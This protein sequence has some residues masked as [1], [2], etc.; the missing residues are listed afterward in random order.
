MD[1]A[2]DFAAAEKRRTLQWVGSIGAGIAGVGVGGGSDVAGGGDVLAPWSLAAATVAGME[3]LPLLSRHSGGAIED[4]ATKTAP[5]MPRVVSVPGSRPGV[6]FSGAQRVE[7]AGSDNAAADAWADETPAPFQPASAPPNSA[8]INDDRVTSPPPFYNGERRRERAMTASRRKKGFSNPASPPPRGATIA[9]MPTPSPRSYPGGAGHDD[10]PLGMK[11][12]TS[13]QMPAPSTPPVGATTPA[14]PTVGV[15][16]PHT[17]RLR[18]LSES[19]ADNFAGVRRR[20]E[21]SIMHG[22]PFVSW[23]NLVSAF[24]RLRFPYSVIVKIHQ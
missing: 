23:L 13:M 6:S 10:F 7:A 12:R 19:T 20:K 14:T 1:T 11:Q 18:Q 21:V 24:C 22:F 2:R 16:S 9:E 8:P 3:P 15:P 4:A 5:A 17:R